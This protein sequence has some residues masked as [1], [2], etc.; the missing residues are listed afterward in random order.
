MEIYLRIDAT[1]ISIHSV[2]QNG[3]EIRVRFND[4]HQTIYLDV[5]HAKALLKLLTYSLKLYSVENE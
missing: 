4:I 3:E 1:E 2:T 5:P